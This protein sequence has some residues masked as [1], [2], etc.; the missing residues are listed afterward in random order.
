MKGKIAVNA[1][2]KHYILERIADILDSIPETTPR[3]SEAGG[4]PAEDAPVEML[5]VK[6]CSEAVKGLSVHTV[7]LLAARGEIPSFRTGAGKSGKILIPKAA[8]VDY[9]KRLG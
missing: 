2:I 1:K 5:T 8:L 6:E 7:R 3:P 9:V 4:P